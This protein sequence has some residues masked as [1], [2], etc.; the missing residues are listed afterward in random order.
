MLRCG[1]WRK[2]AAVML[3]FSKVVKLFEIFFITDCTWFSIKFTSGLYAIATP[4]V[5]RHILK[6][7]CQGSAIRAMNSSDINIFVHLTGD[8]GTKNVMTCRLSACVVP[9]LQTI[10]R[11]VTGCSQMCGVNSKRLHL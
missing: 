9:I 2:R 6:L 4:Y 8:P 11:K 10:H 3:I 1:R 7:F 5:P